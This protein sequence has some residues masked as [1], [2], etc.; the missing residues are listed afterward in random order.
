[1][2]ETSIISL[3]VGLGAIFTSVIIVLVKS[4]Q[5]QIKHELN[6]MNR[7]LAKLSKTFVDLDKNV[8]VMG[9]IIDILSEEVER[10]REHVEKE[11]KDGK[12]NK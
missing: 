8:A 11:S 12:G 5:S 3:V 2:Q 9:K 1:M 10:F 7:N 4:F 6:E